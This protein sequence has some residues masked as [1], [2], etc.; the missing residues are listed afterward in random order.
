MEEEKEWDL[1]KMKSRPNP[2]VKQ[3]KKQITLQNMHLIIW[4]YQ[5]KKEYEA[6]FAEA[7]GPDG[8][9]ATTA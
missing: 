8:V 6:E 3:L 1:S 2:Y 7:Y 5:V 4:E 9:A